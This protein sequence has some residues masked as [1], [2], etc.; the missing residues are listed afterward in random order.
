MKTLTDRAASAGLKILLVDDVPQG[1]VARKTILVSLGYEVETAETGSQAL[2]L[3]AIH[4]FHLMVT[5]YKMPVMDGLQLIQRVRA[6]Y[7]A[8]RVIMLS[9]MADTLGF[10]EAFSG[11]DAV[12]AKSGTELN[13]LTRMISKLLAK[14]P[15]RKP[16]GSQGKSS[17]F[18]V[19]SS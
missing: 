3:L 7:P 11:A 6:E 2:E 4:T 1:T 14:K 13:Q 8:M 9:A 17:A 10:T 19:K 15:A 12:I 16:A 18:V 5:D